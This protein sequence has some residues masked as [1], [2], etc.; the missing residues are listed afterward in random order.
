MRWLKII[1][2]EFI[3]RIWALRI[4]RYCGHC[5]EIYWFVKQRSH[6]N[7]HCFSS[8]FRGFL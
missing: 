3:Y 7:Y 5:D 1:R 2:A 4:K 8:Q 6:S